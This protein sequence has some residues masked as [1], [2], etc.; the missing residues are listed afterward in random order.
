MHTILLLHG[1]LGTKRQLAF[2]ADGLDHTRCL[3][4]TFSGHGQGEV[5]PE[6]L[7]FDLFLADIDA[8]LEKE[9]GP[10]HLFG[11]SMGGYAALLWAARHPGRVASVA[12]LGTKL[13]WTEDGLRK[14]L[15]RLDPAT[16]EEKVPE[17]AMGLAAAHGPARWKDLVAHT[18]ALIERT[19]AQPPLTDAVLAA[20]ECPVLLCVGDRDSTAVPGDTL[21]VAGQLKDAGVLVLPRTRHPF[22]DADLDLLITQLSRFWEGVAPEE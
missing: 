2:L 1:A 11:Y 13:L 9:S 17:F 14:E 10:V 21:R 15:A 19:A 3:S 12:T 18:A 16:M 7:S 4:P 8:A 5:P 22:E 20:I 6:G